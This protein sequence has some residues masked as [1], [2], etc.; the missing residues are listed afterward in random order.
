V[1]Y[2]TTGRA[3]MSKLEKLICLADSIEPSRDY[4]GVDKMREA[5]RRDLNEA[6]L[7]SFDR[8]I[9]YIKQRGLNMNKTTLSARDSI[10]KERENGNS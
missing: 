7:L 6:L 4:E 2:H 5:A 1:R 10:R 3:G 9:E 8:L